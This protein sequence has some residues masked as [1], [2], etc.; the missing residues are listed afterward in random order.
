MFPWPRNPAL[1][2]LQ[3]WKVSFFL[4]AANLGDAIAAYLQASYREWDTNILLLNSGLQKPVVHP[5]GRLGQ[6]EPKSLPPNCAHNPCLAHVLF[7]QSG[8]AWLLRTRMPYL[9]VAMLG[10][11]EKSRKGLLQLLIR[12]MDLGFGSAS[13]E[14]DLR[15]SSSSLDNKQRT[16]I[17]IFKPIHS[18]QNSSQP[19][20][21]ETIL[22]NTILFH[23][24]SPQF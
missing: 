24:V 16:G 20:S 17:Y 23:T 11:C 9:Y 12:L 5:I 18:H 14:R 13:S 7:L 21:L 2:Q 3:F 8:S 10:S 15:S 1:I 22:L 4:D 19:H 6:R